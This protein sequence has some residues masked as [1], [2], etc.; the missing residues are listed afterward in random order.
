MHACDTAFERWESTLS[1]NS[2]ARAPR[3]ARAQNF[4]CSKNIVFF[5]INV[6]FHISSRNFE[7]ARR[8]A[9]ALE[10]SESMDSHLSNVVSHACIRRLLIFLVS[11]EI[12]HKI[13]KK[14]G[15]SCPDMNFNKFVFNKFARPFGRKSTSDDK[16]KL[17]RRQKPCGKCKQN[18]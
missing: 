15:G 7:R 4:W 17:F 16:N 11:F 6:N 10:F 5:S 12:P 2:S 9:R 8:G 13:E 14:V 18:R 1:E 3:Q